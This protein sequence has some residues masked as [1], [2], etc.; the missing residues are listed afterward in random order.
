MG[1]GSNS[2]ERRRFIRPLIVKIDC[3]GTG[4]SLQETRQARKKQVQRKKHW[5]EEEQKRGAVVLRAWPRGS[6][7]PQ[8][9]PPSLER[10]A[11]R[12]GSFQMGLQKNRLEK[13]PSKEEKNSEGWR[14]RGTDD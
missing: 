6:V 10:V 4:K 3:R 5:L 8:K 9:G 14:L 13:K 11:R 12:G 7:V 2:W 1:G